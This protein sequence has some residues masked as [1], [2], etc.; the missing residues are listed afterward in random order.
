MAL[1]SLRNLRQLLPAHDGEDRQNATEFQKAE[2]MTWM[3][4]LGSQLMVS[5]ATLG[6]LKMNDSKGNTTG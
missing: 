3:V 4:T 6:T 1:D 2:A 5:L